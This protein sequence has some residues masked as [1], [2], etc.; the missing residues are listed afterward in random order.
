MERHELVD[1]GVDP[2]ERRRLACTCGWLTINGSMEQQ[3]R[4]FEAHIKR[5]EDKYQEKVKAMPINMQ[6]RAIKNRRKK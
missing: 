6:G 3:H 1:R 5:I 2:V 4:A